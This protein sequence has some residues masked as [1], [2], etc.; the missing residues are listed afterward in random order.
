[1]HVLRLVFVLALV[2]VA[3]P[4]AA[5]APSAKK[6]P[7][8]GILRWIRD[9]DL[10]KSMREALGEHGYVDGRNV[11]IEE[12]WA[13]GRS[14]LA[15]RHAA[16]FVRLGFD[17][18]VAGGTPAVRAALEATRTVPIVMSGSADPVASGFAVSLA[19]PGGNVTGISWNLP[20]LAGKRLELLR[21][22]LPD[23]S[24]VV[25][26]GS[27][28]DPAARL[29]VEETRSAGRRLGVHVHVAMVNDATEF[30]AA[31]SEAV[32][33]RAQALIVQPIFGFGD[34]LK[35]VVELA[36]KH[37]L[38]AISDF[39]E[40]ASSG[41]LMSYG[42]SR[43]DMIRRVAVYVDRILKGAKP[44]ELPI[45]EPTRFVLVL[46]MRT[47]KALGLTIPQPILSR[48]DEIVQ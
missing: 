23:V 16:E 46:N 45:E 27:R 9:A 48:A 33:D 38:P 39:P 36:H 19:Q 31:L 37:H 11:V 25:F 5:D 40:F 21:Q 29:F 28:R 3:P 41:G 42:P 43:R 6:V 17:V 10:E 7:Q 15:V 4:L 2:L 14:D 32:R 26:L 35:T 20:A 18:I 44:G 34:T 1:M 47:A 30:D 24:R 12:R 8:V 22:T 13:N